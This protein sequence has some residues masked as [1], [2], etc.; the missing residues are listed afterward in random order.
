MCRLPTVINLSHSLL[1]LQVWLYCCVAGAQM[2]P[3]LSW[4]K[5]MPVK[6]GAGSLVTQSSAASITVTKPV[7]VMK[8]DVLIAFIWNDKTLGAASAVTTPAGW[9]LLGM[10][11][12]N[13]FTANQYRLSTYSRVSDGTDGANYTW[14]FAATDSYSS[15][16][17]VAYVGGHQLVAVDVGPVFTAAVISAGGNQTNTGVTTVNKDSKI[18]SYYIDESTASTLTGPAG[19]S[20]VAYFKDTGRNMTVGLWE[21]TLNTP[22]ATGGITGSGFTSG[23]TKSYFGVTLAVRSVS[24]GVGGACAGASV[25]GYCWYLGGLG[26]SCTTMCTPRGGYNNA[27][28]TYAGSSGTWAQCS[29]VMGALGLSGNTA[30]GAVA[31]GV[32]VGC[33]A[34]GI[35][36]GSSTNS[37]CNDVATTAG[38]SAPTL[39]RACACNN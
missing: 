9:T 5:P 30:G 10:Q 21:K 20:Q 37:L 23:G 32:V 25:G 7:G 13:G 34:N 16:V 18:L 14:S 38:A 17:V 22:G 1:M 36:P 3:V 39:Y 2:I 4:Q 15:G 35:N 11:Q 19:Y 8:G 24:S 26:E 6:R 33:S 28:L 12:A 31:C 27:T 29:S